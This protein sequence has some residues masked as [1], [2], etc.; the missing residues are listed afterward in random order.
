MNTVILRSALEDI[1][2]G[3]KFYESQDTGLGEYFENSIFSDIAKL[4]EQAGIHRQVHGY[5]RMLATR[6]PFAIYYRVEENELRIRGI[7][8]CRRAPDW[9]EQRLG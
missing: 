4:K 7:L 2:S 3:C 8:D 9:I 1:E 6:L 5:H